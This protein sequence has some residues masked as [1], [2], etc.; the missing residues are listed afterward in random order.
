MRLKLQTTT[1]PILFLILLSAFIPGTN[2]HIPWD[3]GIM[4]GDLTISVKEGMKNGGFVLRGAFVDNQRMGTW[5]LTNDMGEVLLRRVY[6]NSICYQSD[7]FSTPKLI[8]NE[9]GLYVYGEIKEKDIVYAKRVQMLIPEDMLN[10]NPEFNVALQQVDLHGLSAYTGPDLRKKI[11]IKKAEIPQM[12]QLKE[13]R[14]SGDWFYDKKRKTMVFTVLAF[15]PVMRNQSGPEL[16]YYYPDLRERM[17]QIPMQIENA[18]I[19]TLDDYFFLTAFPYLIYKAEGEKALPNKDNILQEFTYYFLEEL[20]MK[21]A[22][23]WTE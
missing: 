15:N 18:M 17:A 23:L 22:G 21:E 4:N 6:Q 9:Q 12:I 2:N 8:R 10:N 13:L 14:L 1:I 11:K 5:T 20:F 19:N 16:W 7:N 3:N